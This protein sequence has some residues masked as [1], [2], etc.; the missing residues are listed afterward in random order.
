MLCTEEE[1]KNKNFFISQDGKFYTTD[2]S[3]TLDVL[4]K[5]L[6][7][8]TQLE[9]NKNYVDYLIND[10]GYVLYEHVGKEID[11]KIPKYELNGIMMS[12]IQK[13]K[14]VDYV[15]NFEQQGSAILTLAKILELDSDGCTLKIQ[16][17]GRK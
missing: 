3:E 12:K 5:S 17:R 11:I 15:I 6:I 10:L 2:E 4:A 14:L 16:R 13:K 8:N 1:L 7:K 9:S